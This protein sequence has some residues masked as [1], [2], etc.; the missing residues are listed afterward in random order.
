[1]PGMQGNQDLRDYRARHWENRKEQWQ[2]ENDRDAARAYRRREA[3]DGSAIV[4]MSA[5]R[6]S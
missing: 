4:R 3:V 2:Q 1:M 6:V 5:S